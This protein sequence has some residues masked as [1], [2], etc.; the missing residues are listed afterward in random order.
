MITSPFIFGTTV[1][2][3]AFINRTDEIK[4][5]SDNLTSGINTSLISPRRWGKSSLVEKTID[6]LVK[7][8][9]NIRIAMIDLFTVN[10]SEQFLEKFARELIKA[11]ST[12]WQEWVK[13]TRLFFK[14]LIPK[15]NIGI[16]PAHDFSIS[17]DWREMKKNEEEILNLP[18][19]IAQQKKIKII[20]CIDEFQNIASFSDFESFEKKLRAI[21][22]R[23]HNVTYCIYGSRRHM[24]KDIFNNPSKPFYRFGDIILLEKIDKNE[25]VRFITG[26][27]KKTDKQISMDEAALIADLMQ[28]HPWYVQQ[29]AHYTW[30]LTADKTTKGTIE[31]ALSE[32]INANTPFYQTEAEILSSTQLNLLI[33]VLKGEKQLTSVSAMNTYRLGTPRNVS[34]NKTQLINSDIIQATGNGFEFVDPAF[35]LWFRQTF[36]NQPIHKHFDPEVKSG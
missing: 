11:S 29:L 14:M 36:L 19:T 27:F 30:N 10:S 7:K 23:Q 35:E 26:S 16:D 32:L 3:E 12:K 21:W 20:V 34:R 1:T 8:N 15:I 4:K 31:K 2:D 25:W 17:F 28:C 22:Q 6:D 24:M 5:L 9:K 18:E 33:A 13:N